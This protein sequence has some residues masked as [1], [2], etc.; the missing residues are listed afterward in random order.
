MSHGPISW[1]DKTSQLMMWHIW[2]SHCVRCVGSTCTMY[3]VIQVVLSYTYSWYKL[4]CHTHMN[5]IW[6]S[7]VVICVWQDNLYN[8]MLCQIHG[9]SWSDT[10]LIPMCMTRLI[11]TFDT[12]L[13]L[14]CM[15]RLIY[16]SETWLIPMCMTRLIHTFDTRLIH[17][18]MTR[19][20]ISF[21]VCRIQD[22]SGSD[23]WLIH[24]CMTRLIYT[25]DIWLIPMC[26][27]RSDT[28]LIHVCMTRQVVSFNVVSDTWLCQ[29][30]H[31]ISWSH[32]N[33]RDWWDTSTYDQL[34]SYATHQL[35]RL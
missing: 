15:T 19:Q 17:V 10:W 27:T 22:T 32:M 31:I 16:T 24:M 25:S 11:Y 34:I 4:Y 2:H 7:R 26:M 29:M 14:T 21:N 6:M 12:W 5:I 9:T 3:F 28:W 35:M 20:V 1:C 30:C 8:S 18:C 23:T 13:I 33:L